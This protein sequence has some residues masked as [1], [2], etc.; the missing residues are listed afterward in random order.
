MTELTQEAISFI[1]SIEKIHIHNWSVTKG[2]RTFPT[3][4]ALML[5]RS[6]SY[7]WMFVYIKF[8]VKREA[9]SLLK[10]SF[11]PALNRDHPQWDPFLGIDSFET[12]LYK[13]AYIKGSAYTCISARGL[14]QF[15]EIKGGGGRGWGGRCWSWH[16]RI[17]QDYFHYVKHWSGVTFT[18]QKSHE[19][20]SKGL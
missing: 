7:I 11:A 1:W 9:I 20:T 2:T 10:A 16:R 3:V 12:H 13:I 18:C 15:K 6:I 19:A 17:T 14:P 4:N 5:G 8:I